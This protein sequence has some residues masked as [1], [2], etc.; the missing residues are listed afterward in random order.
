MAFQHGKDG[1]EV[2]GL[3]SLGALGALGWWQ[4]ALELLPI[5][6]QNVLVFCSSDFCL[7]CPG[8]WEDTVAAVTGW[9]SGPA[10]RR[11]RRS[12]LFH[13][14]VAKPWGWPFPRSLARALFVPAFF[15]MSPG[16]C[17]VLS[18]VGC[19]HSFALHS[20]LAR[21]QRHRE[22]ELLAKATR[23]SAESLELNSGGQAGSRTPLPSH[24]P[25][26]LLVRQGVRPWLS[27]AQPGAA[28][29]EDE[30]S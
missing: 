17:H 26:L 5:P 2:W 7:A 30:A 9:A 18:I 21:K 25:R 3:S 12:L 16:A 14:P 19:I 11:L 15:D 8:P 1:D 20:S 29:P 10:P 22:L 4:A 13:E 6:M 24:C 28:W 27:G 23:C